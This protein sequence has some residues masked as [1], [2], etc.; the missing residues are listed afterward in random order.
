MAKSKK[1]LTTA[2]KHLRG[3]KQFEIVV[4]TVVDVPVTIDARSEEEALKWAVENSDVL[5]P[6]IRYVSRKARLLFKRN[7]TPAEKQC[8]LID[9]GL[10]KGDYGATAAIAQ[11]EAAEA[12]KK[13]LAA[14]AK[15][16]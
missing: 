12:N 7:L 6:D 15:I 4:R 9:E 1:T 8:I 11:K 10:A 14:L 2:E 5:A 13:A 16:R 3:R